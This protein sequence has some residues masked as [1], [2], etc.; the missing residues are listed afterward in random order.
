M[1]KFKRWFIGPIFN[2]K[3]GPAEHLEKNVPFFG[4][5]FYS[6]FTL[7][8]SPFPP[9]KHLPVE[10][11]TLIVGWKFYRT[12]DN[13]FAGAIADEAKFVLKHGRMFNYKINYFRDADQKAIS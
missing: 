7:F 3:I 10:K 5:L 1:S 9:H 6:K 12:V 13:L 11:P 4:K 2:S 8:W